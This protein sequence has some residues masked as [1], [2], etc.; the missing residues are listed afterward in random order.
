[1]S[2]ILIY[3][4]LNCRSEPC[5]P[6]T[7]PE[8]CGHSS[9][10]EIGTQNRIPLVEWAVPTV[11]L[12]KKQNIGLSY[13][14]HVSVWVLSAVQHHKDFLYGHWGLESRLN[15]MLYYPDPWQSPSL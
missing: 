13:I 11:H 12:R 5:S 8:N 15:Q 10:Y 2:A 4:I 9:P 1:M 14:S 7:R 6:N 3:R